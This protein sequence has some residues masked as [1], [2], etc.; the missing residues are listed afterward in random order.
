MNYSKLIEISSNIIDIPQNYV[1]ES[2]KYNLNVLS[3]LDNSPKLQKYLRRHDIQRADVIRLKQFGD[4]RNNGK[5]IYDGENF[6]E[7]DYTLDPYGSVP[8]LFLL[9]EFGNNAFYFHYSIDHNNIVYIEGQRYNI[10]KTKT[11]NGIDGLFY[12]V[13]HRKLMTKWT[14]YSEKNESDFIKVLDAGIFDNAES[15]EFDYDELMI[16]SHKLLLECDK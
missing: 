13:K 11:F 9:E 6:M 1:D 10:S 8:V 14:I 16:D 5:F 3:L 15:C 12:Y 4:Y 7:L 2:P